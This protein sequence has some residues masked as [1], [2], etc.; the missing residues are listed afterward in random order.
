METASEPAALKL[1]ALAGPGGLKADGA[2][3]ALMQVEVVDSEGRR[4]PTALN[5]VAFSLSGPAEWR[6]GIAQGPDNFI[7]AK[8]LPVECGVNRVLVRSS[9]E[10]GKI[11]LSAESPDLEPASTEIISQSVGQVGPVGLAG[12]FPSDGLPSCLLRGPTPSGPAYKI[13]RQPV[14]IAR[15]TAG[16]NADR[17]AASFD[18]NETTSWSSDGKPGT[19]WISYEF[20]RPATV[21]EATLKL[22]GWRTR[23]YSLHITVDGEEVF[24]GATPRSLGYVT[25]PLRP[26]QGQTLKIELI[27]ASA[28]GAQSIAQREPD[29]PAPQSNTL[30]STNQ[31][32]FAMTELTDE[33]NASTGD[34]RLASGSL[35]IVEAEFYEP[36]RR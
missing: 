32:A 5:T 15:A 22:T 30:H 12:Y 36:V 25:L 23:S 7:L 33:K 21:T 10:A 28:T 3:V 29:Q 8:S 24:R 35:S 4:C 26:V 13:T 2:D 18:D 19:A 1:T 31:E 17:A 16:S 20:A 11:V 9:T 27:S 14:L 6:G 34:E